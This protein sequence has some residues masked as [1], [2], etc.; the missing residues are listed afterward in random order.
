M[1]VANWTHSLIE[2][3]V[4]W[5][6]VGP[7][8]DILRPWSEMLLSGSTTYI[9]EDFIVSITMDDTPRLAF[10]TST[11][12]PYVIHDLGT[13]SLVTLGV[14]EL[15]SEDGTRIRNPMTGSESVLVGGAQIEFVTSDQKD[16]AEIMTTSATNVPPSYFDFMARVP[17]DGSLVRAAG[18]DQVWRIVGGKKFS[19]G[20]SP[21]QVVTVSRSWIDEVPYGPL[22][23]QKE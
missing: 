5:I 13:Y 4:P 16:A 14:A 12:C 7:P 15:P 8:S 19:I 9:G 11:S 18:E 23:W 6:T 1:I 22:T 10:R 20:S 2:Y 3:N 21:G 17:L